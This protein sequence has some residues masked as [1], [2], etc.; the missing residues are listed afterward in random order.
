MTIYVGPCRLLLGKT[1]CNI[2]LRNF[3]TPQEIH[4]VQALYH[5]MHPVTHS[6]THF[7]TTRVPIS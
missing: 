7:L 1:I 3:S 2:N 6:L 5:C 4:L